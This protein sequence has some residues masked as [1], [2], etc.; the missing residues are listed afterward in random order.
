MNLE[1]VAFF[2]AIG[3][4]ALGAVTVARIIEGL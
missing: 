3:L 1:V 4:A 2:I